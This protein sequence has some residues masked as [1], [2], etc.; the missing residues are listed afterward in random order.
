MKRFL[1]TFM[2]I[3]AALM[4]PSLS[5]CTSADKTGS[6]SLK[7][8]VSVDE[9]V[10]ILPDSKPD[11][12][13]AITKADSTSGNRSILVEENP[14]DASGSQKALARLNDQ[15]RIYQRSGSDLEKIDQSALTTGKKVSVWFD[16]P[17]AQSYPVQGSASVVLLED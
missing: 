15:T 5:A 7:S 2:L 12:R 14:G 4:Q 10:K 11:I 17:V 13:G 16:G 8:T 1:I 9:S 6:G 3:V